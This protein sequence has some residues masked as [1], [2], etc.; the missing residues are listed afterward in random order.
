MRESILLVDDVEEQ[1][2]IAFGI[3]AKL[4]YTVNTVSSGEEAIDYLKNQ[5]N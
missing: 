2:E 3:L 1:R 4:G 5:F